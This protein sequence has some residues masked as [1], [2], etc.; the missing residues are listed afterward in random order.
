MRHL[1]YN[2]KEVT[3]MVSESLDRKLPLHQRMGI[4]VHLFMCKF[5]SRYRKQLL[6]L[7]AVMQRY[8][9]SDDSVDISE[10]LSPTAK[11]RMKHVLSHHD[12]S[13]HR[14]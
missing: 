14:H 1:M 11:K 4:R 13:D 5:C 12:D 6:L 2:C 10:S 7:R 3:R 9:E 8:A